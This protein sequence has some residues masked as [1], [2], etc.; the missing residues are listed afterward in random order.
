MDSKVAGKLRREQCLGIIDTHDRII[1]TR[2]LLQQVLDHL[3]FDPDIPDQDLQKNLRPIERLSRAGSDRLTP[4]IRSLKFQ[5]WFAS[6]ASNILFVNCAFHGSAEESPSSFLCAHLVSSVGTESK[7]IGGLSFFCK[8]HSQSTDPFY[9]AAGLLKS[10]LGQVL[11]RFPELDYSYLRNRSARK[12][13]G[14]GVLYGAIE[15]LLMQLSP[16]VVL[17]F[18]IKGVNIYKEQSSAY[19]EVEEALDFLIG[20][21]QRSVGCA[22]KILISCSWNSH[23]LHKLAPDQESMILW[24]PSKVVSQPRLT[25]T[26]WNSFFEKNF[27]SLR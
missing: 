4:I 19:D 8:E 1:G 3:V 22:F 21:S 10:F 15:N 7:L 25:S 14:I 9:S 27:H 18:A 5:D 6:P 16:E 23:K 24:I 12:G 2:A 26:T 11:L 13:I 17:I 20:M